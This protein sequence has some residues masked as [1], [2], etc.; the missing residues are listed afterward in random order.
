MSS[1][2]QHIVIIGGG[3]CGIMTLVHLLENSTVPLKISLINSG[4]P[5]AKGIAYNT[6]SDLH[7]LN[8]VAGNMSAYSDRPDDFTDWVHQKKEYCNIDK[9]ILARTFLPRGL[10]GQYLKEIWNKA[11]AN[12]K[13]NIELNLIDDTAIDVEIGENAVVVLLKSGKQ[14]QADKLVIATG[15][16]EPRDPSIPNAAFFSSPAYFRNS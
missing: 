2:S 11:L 14:V 3:F 13:D 15:N 5:L 16:S 10:Y 7:L 1:K 9:D 4:Y 12:K 6:Y 8:V